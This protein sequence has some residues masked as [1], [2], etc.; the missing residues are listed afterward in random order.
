MRFKEFIR[1]QSESCQDATIKSIYVDLWDKLNGINSYSNNINVTYTNTKAKKEYE[2]SLNESDDSYVKNKTIYI[3]N[4]TSCKDK[5]E[6]WLKNGHISTISDD[7]ISDDGWE[8]MFM[9]RADNYNFYMRNGQY[10]V[11]PCCSNVL[12]AIGE[13][14]INIYEDSLVKVANTLAF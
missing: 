14:N 3:I 1:V 10:F 12:S 9:G 4:V 11:R 13:D 7:I 2:K 5:D 8:Y 6:N